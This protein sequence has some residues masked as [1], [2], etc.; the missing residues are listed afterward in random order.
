MPEENKPA[1]DEKSVE[2]AEFMEE[3]YPAQDDTPA[4]DDPPKGDE[5]PAKDDPPAKD[6]P[7]KGD[8]PTKN[9]PP[10]LMDGKK[11]DEPAKEDSDVDLNHIDE[12]L[13]SEMKE[14]IRKNM[15]NMRRALGSSKEKIEKYKT[16]LAE[17]QEKGIL[18][19]QG[20]LITDAV[21]PEL[22]QDLEKAYDQIGALSLEHDPRFQA[23][24]NKPIIQHEAQIVALLKGNSE[25]DSDAKL[26]LQK[27][28]R[29]SPADRV[30]FLNEAAPDT[31]AFT[32]QYFMKLDELY[33][34]RAEALRAHNETTKQMQEAQLTNEAQRTE[35]LRETL[36]TTSL[37]E[38]ASEGVSI[39]EKIPGNDEYNN[40][41]DKVLD[42]VDVL[43]KSH[44]IKTQ[45]KALALSVAAPVC[46]GLTV[47]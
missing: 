45:S 36:K 20:K 3:N 4:K 30:A 29:M 15:G 8:D 23:Q 41:V 16:Q 19:E 11:T 5:P 47:L 2:M 25:D 38:L 18:D 6:E 34:S 28:V 35:Q 31:A 44:D 9:L 42:H 22:K 37:S 43:F 33:G 13:K 46:C 27:A 39:F 14:D 7:P 40:W 1:E 12:L 10:E 21:N 17:L 32:A 24:Y 26:I